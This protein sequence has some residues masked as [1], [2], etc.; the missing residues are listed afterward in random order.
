MILLFQHINAKHCQ[1]ITTPPPHP[2]L[3]SR[4]NAIEGS[5]DSHHI[6]SGRTRYACIFSFNFCLLTNTPRPR[7]SK[8]NMEEGFSTHHHLCLT[9]PPRLA[10][11][12]VEGCPP[13]PPPPPSSHVSTRGEVVH[14]HH[15]HLPPS[16]ET[17]AVTHHHPPPSHFDTTAGVFTHHHLPPCHFDVTATPPPLS[18]FDATAGV[19]TTHLPLVSTRQ[20]G[21]P[22]SHSSHPS[23]L[24]FDAQRGSFS[25]FIM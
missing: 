10:Y 13:P 5:F 21:P 7:C 20:R 12:H 25:I 8:R 17:R 18:Q 24:R 14:N 3:L 16:P 6:E 1:L 15:H 11:R 9:P 22:P 2:P 23:V 4:F 19:F